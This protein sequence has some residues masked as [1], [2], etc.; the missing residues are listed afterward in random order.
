MVY[1]RARIITTWLVELFRFEFE[2]G[3]NLRNVLVTEETIIL[4]IPVMP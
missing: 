2:Q 3:D 1:A 4:I